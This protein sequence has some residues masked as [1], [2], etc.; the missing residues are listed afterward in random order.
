VKYLGFVLDVS[1]E[2]E[3]PTEEIEDVNEHLKHSKRSVSNVPDGVR[4][5]DGKCYE[6]DKVSRTKRTKFHQRLVNLFYCCFKNQ[7]SEELK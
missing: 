3:K 2:Q 5:E 7:E 4:H 1:A 6:E